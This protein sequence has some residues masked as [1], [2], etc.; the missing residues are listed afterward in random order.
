[1]P[2]NEPVAHDTNAAD[3][4]S[5][6]KER[7]AR[8]GPTGVGLANLQR[9]PLQRELKHALSFMHFG[10][11]FWRARRSWTAD[12]FQMSALNKKTAASST[13]ASVTTNWSVAACGTASITLV[14]STPRTCIEEAL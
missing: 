14:R 4:E 9:L 11:L 5:L 6:F 3:P 7:A 2:Q 1:M 13:G 10:A 8:I 12:P